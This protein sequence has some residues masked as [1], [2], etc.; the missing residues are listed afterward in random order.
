MQLPPTLKNDL[1]S[2][3]RPKKSALAYETA[4]K[5]YESWIRIHYKLDDEWTLNPDNAPDYITG[6]LLDCHIQES[7]KGGTETFPKPFVA[8]TQ[9]S[10][11]SMLKSEFLTRFQIDI[12]E[13]G[14]KSVASTVVYR[15][16]KKHTPKQAGIITPEQFYEFVRNAPESLFPHKICAILGW[17]LAGRNCE[18]NQLEWTALANVGASDTELFHKG[19]HK[20]VATSL[21][22]RQI[23]ETMTANIS[24]KLHSSY[25]QDAK[26]KIANQDS[27]E[28]PER[29]TKKS[30]VSVEASF[31]LPE[32][33]P[34]ASFV[35]QNVQN[36]TI[37]IHKEDK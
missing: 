27:E 24:D 15:N 20:S 10:Y 21:K 34:S 6:D 2:Q 17:E 5:R 8:S 13:K 26:P 9:T 4:F 7:M 35:F 23:S 33:S 11:L 3:L 37:N 25:L 32:V 29:K 14:F 16:A 19:G 28:V 12:N 36:V 1:K 22:Y 30:N 31:M 18:V